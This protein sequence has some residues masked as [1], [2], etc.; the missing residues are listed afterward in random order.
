MPP[1][2][3]GVAPLEAAPSRPLIGGGNGVK[4]P[5]QE[6]ERAGPA[7]GVRS[8]YTRM[9][10]GF[11]LTA[12]RALMTVLDG[13]GWTSAA[14]VTWHKPPESTQAWKRLLVGPFPN[15]GCCIACKAEAWPC[16]PV[17]VCGRQGSG[18]GMP[19]CWRPRARGLR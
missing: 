14:L 16:L 10:G 3:R 11:G 9:M 12:G 8:L 7:S 15:W 19:W 2:G 13:M 4:R 17:C 6:P 1:P 18:R 5:L